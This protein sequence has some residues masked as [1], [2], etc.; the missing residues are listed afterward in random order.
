MPKVEDPLSFDAVL[1]AAEIYRLLRSHGFTIR[2]PND[3]LIASCAIRNRVSLLHADRD[4]DVI[5][6]FTMLQAVSLSG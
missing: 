3:C 5:A 2:S 4:F 6:R 1:E